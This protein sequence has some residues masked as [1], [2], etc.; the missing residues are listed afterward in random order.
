MV[1]HHLNEQMI[2]GRKTWRF[3][4][5]WTK[6]SSASGES[7]DLYSRLPRGHGHLYRRNQCA[8]LST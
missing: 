1:W 4:H 6:Q 2:P 5:Q 8:G 7:G 3:S